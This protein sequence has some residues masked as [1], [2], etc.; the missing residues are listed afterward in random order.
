MAQG[1]TAAASDEEKDARRWKREL[2]LAKKRERDWFQEADKIIKRYRG[3]E[4][5]RNRYN[6]LWSNT[7][8]LR[9]SIY[10]SRPNPDVRRRFRDSDLIGKAVSEV[11][12]RALSVFVDGD[13]T[14][15]AL[16]NDVLD[17]LLCGRGVSRIRYIPKIATVSAT[18][19]SDD[20]LTTDPGGDASDDGEA[21]SADT[22]DPAITDEMPPDEELE[23]EL[24]CVEHVS[25]KD[26]RHGYGRVWPEVPWVSFRHKLSRPDAEQKFGK[27]AVAKIQF[28]VPDADEDRKATEQVGETQKVAEF[29]EIWDKLGDRVFFT[30]DDCNVLLF[31]EDNS[32]GEPPLEFDGFFPCP[33]PVAVIE[34]TDSLLPIPPFR[35][36]EDQANQL[37]KL[38]GRIDKIINTMRLRGA[39]DARMEEMADILASDD[40]DMVPIKNAQQWA[41]GGL[42]KAVTWMPVEKNAE[43][44]EALYL[45]REKQKAI[46][47]ELTGIS[48][49]IRGATDPNETATAQDLKSTY[50]SVRLQK[51][52]KEVQ[53]YARDLLRLAAGAMAQKFSPQTFQEMTELKFPTA[54]QKQAMIAMFQQQALPPN[55]GAAAP[56]APLPGAPPQPPPGGPPPPPGPPPGPPMD[57]ALLQVPTW[58]DI[59]GLMRSEKRRQFNIDVETDSTIAG[60]LSRDMAG[61]SQ[62]LTAISQAMTELAP[63]VEAGVMPIDAAKEIILTVIRRARMGMAVEDAFDKLQP[64]KPKPDPEAAKAQ[65][66]AQAQAGVAQTKAQADIQVAQIKAQLDAHVAQVEQQSQAAQNEQEQTIEAHRS[67]MEAQQKQQLAAADQAHKEALE[68][69]RLQAE[70]QRSATEL[71]SQRMIADATNETKVIIAHITA[72]SQAAMQAQQ[73]EHEQKIAA[74]QPKPAADGE[75]P[76]AA[77]Y[78]APEQDLGAIMEKFSAVMSRPRKVI[79]DGNGKISGVE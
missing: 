71:E 50:G 51:M 68:Q 26:F 1:G 7:E 17:S 60:T 16:K 10:N 40:N 45:G 46:I 5:K 43:I 32:E 52:Q 48:D 58:D 18:A 65:A 49:I 64:P 70:N 63:M 47:D 22:S 56:Q 34:N 25:W 61:L 59:L 15:D 66:Q 67:A 75:A 41:D 11:L 3:E 14:D 33:R 20:E 77:A 12:E 21:K 2:Q 53:R 6:V 73:Q 30:Q 44:L 35:L 38:S 27:E 8:I 79:R 36:Y 31:P 23:S 72:Q 29:W 19:R 39:Y 54:Q 69:M 74:M 76:T 24:V 9:P 62:V 4:K 37:D 57:P 28:T 42:D 55:A 78:K 13:E